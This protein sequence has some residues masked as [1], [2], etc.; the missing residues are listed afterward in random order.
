MNT[1]QLDEATVETPAGVEGRAHLGCFDCG[2]PLF[3]STP[4]D[5][6]E[7]ASDECWCTGDGLFW[8]ETAPMPC[9]ECGGVSRVMVS[10]GVAYV[11]EVEGTDPPAERDTGDLVVDFPCATL[12]D[13]TPDE[14]ATFWLRVEQHAPQ[15]A[16]VTVMMPAIQV[17]KGPPVV[18]FEDVE[19]ETILVEA[20]AEQVK[21]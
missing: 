16:S 6:E 21:S 14:W 4:C 8:L 5:P 1:K 19:P 10:D 12:R 17:G 15:Y 18:V 20:M 3:P 2:Y 11:S 13:V 9:P 7:H